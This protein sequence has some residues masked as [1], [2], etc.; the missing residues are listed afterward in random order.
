MKPPAPP[1]STP[2]VAEPSVQAQCRA[3]REGR[4][5]EGS[6]PAARSDGESGSYP[7]VKDHRVGVG[8]PPPTGWRWAA[9]PARSGQR[10][11]PRAKQAS[12]PTV[13]Q[14]VTVFSRGLTVASAA[15]RSGSSSGRAFAFA[16]NRA[17]RAVL[18]AD[19]G[20]SLA[21]AIRASVGVERVQPVMMRAASRISLSNTST[22][23]GDAAGSH[24]GAACSRAP[25]T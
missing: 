4:Q 13:R 22:W 14:P 11:L 12:R 23:E 21:S 7:Q 15:L 2:P 9:A 20:A 17:A 8:R 3:L 10:H 6:G 16:R 1:S 18:R 5:V 24:A 19:T 25:L